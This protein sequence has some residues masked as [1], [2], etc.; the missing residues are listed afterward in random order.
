MKHRIIG[1]DAGSPAEKAGVEVGWYLSRINCETV[2]DVIDYEQLTAHSRLEV[3]FI[4]E[5]HGGSCPVDAQAQEGNG[6]LEATVAEAGESIY[7]GSV[8]GIRDECVEKK[9]AAGAASPVSRTE[10][11]RLLRIRKGEYDPL[12][13]NFESGLMSRVRQ[14]ANHC[15]FCFIDQMPHGNRKTLYFK[16]D[17]WRLSLIMGNYV[18]LTNVSEKEFERILSRRAAPLYITV[19]ATDGEV[20]KRMLRGKN[21]ENLLERLKRLHENGLAFHCQIVLCPEINDGEV[22]EKT[23]ADLYALRPECRSVAVVPLGITK[24]REG[25]TKLTPMNRE[26]AKAAV[27][28]VEGFRKRHGITDF[29]Y[30]SDEMYLAAGLTLPEYE[31]YGDFEQIEN[32]VGMYRLFEHDF[33]MMLDTLEK[34]SERIELDS[35]SGVSIAPLMQ[36]LFDKLLPYNIRITVH[37]VLNDFFG[38]TITVTGLIT[39]R[40]ILSQLEGRLHGKALLLPYT[41]LRENDTVFLDG[42]RIAEVSERLSMPVYKISASDGAD[43]IDELDAIAKELE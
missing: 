18:T 2:Y 4:I 15:I 22:L 35:V 37:P 38:H 30:A 16:D 11:R 41:M 33:L 6:A 1:V 3:E 40:D 27:E 12:G 19:H 25:L 13:L 9:E 43:F 28:Q 23:L 5:T 34:R 29:C 31:E 20:R 8:T 32:G 36:A 42:L 10:E 39:A 17:D 24:H 26:R 14:C 21:A 7:S